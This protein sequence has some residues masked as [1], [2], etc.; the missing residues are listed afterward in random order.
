[1]MFFDHCNLVDNCVPPP[2]GQFDFSFLS[3]SSRIEEV[4]T[5]IFYPGLGFLLLHLHHVLVFI[6]LCL[7][8]R[9]G[10]AGAV[11]QTPALLI[12]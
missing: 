8:N 10:L 9:P 12:N 11:L 7:F 6:Q 3:E 4:I 1:M 5:T 2:S